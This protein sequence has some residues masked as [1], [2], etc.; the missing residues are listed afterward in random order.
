M[1]EA[2]HKR[3][4]TVSFHLFEVQGQAKLMYGDRGQRSG[5]LWRVKIELKGA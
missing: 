4:Y 2:T 5:C 1:K 3:I